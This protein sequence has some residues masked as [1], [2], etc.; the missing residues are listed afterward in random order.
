M[1]EQKP[2]IATTT[3]GK[4]R[5]SVRDSIH[6]FKGVRYGA[7]TSTTRFAA[8]Q[9]PAPWT[10]VRDALEYGNSSPQ[11]PSGDAGGLFASWRPQPAFPLSEDC[12]FLN[13]WTPGVGDGKKRPILVW[14]H[15]GGFVTGSG[16][17][18]AYE[19][20]R[21]AKRGDV[22]VITIN[23]RLNVF[24]HLYLG[25]YGDEFA[26]SGNAGVLDIVLAL[27][28]VR[29]N[30]AEFGG[31]AGNV[32]I[33]G[34]SGGGAKVSV[35]MNTDRAKG[36]FHR[37]IVQSGPWLRLMAA[38]DASANA[39]RMVEA[40][41]LTRD[42]IGELRKL[43]MEQIL[44][45]WRKAAPAGRGIADGPVLDY[46]TFTRHP[47]EPDAAPQGRSV[48][49]MIGVCSTETSLLAGAGQPGLFDLTWT[50]LREQ[51]A[52][53]LAGLD[54][55]ATIEAYRRLHPDYTP[56]EAY[57]RITTER[58]FFR[59]SMLQA[60]RKAAQGGA[61][62]F[63]YILEWKTPVHGGKWHTPHA[64]DI[65][66]VFDNVARSESMSGVGDDQQRLADIMSETWLAFARTGDPNNAQ[67]PHWPA[68]D[69]ER[70]ASM[71]LDLEPRVENDP[72][73]AERALFKRPP[74]PAQVAPS[75]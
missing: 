41:G 70:R 3:A 1:H 23:H 50:S 37:G 63:F 12:L 2:S 29:D 32:T 30:A 67:L 35:L 45:G 51:L 55:V 22:V 59:S 6:V 11:G 33:F 8:P 25:A 49:M 58:G 7:D 34:E 17:S 46:R 62:T 4:I 19:G 69:A 54:P 61:P 44:Q 14:L 47:F 73:A 9:A 13:V 38:E 74:R 10:D 68:Y 24:G 56:A 27:E 36:L 18:N 28:W 60:E 43:S 64:L 20:T 31:D 26:D 65:G 75:P 42:R 48:P 71:V 5:G 72:R 15:G 57:F 21:L 40:L 53:Q 39:A 52:P 16:S 66:F